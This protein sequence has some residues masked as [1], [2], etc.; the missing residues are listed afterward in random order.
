MRHAGG[1]SASLG[2][3]VATRVI[4]FAILGSLR[5][6][7]GDRTVAL[8]GGKQRALLAL[9]L[10]HRNQV[11]AADR[12]IEELWSGEPPAT[13]AKIVQLYVSQLRKALGDGVLV[14]R[15]PGYVLNV[16]GGGTRC[17]PLR[18]VAG[19]WAAHA[20]RGGRRDRPARLREALALWRGPPLSDFAYEAFAQGEI[21]RLAE[22]HLA[23]SRS[24]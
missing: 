9:L 7:E 6:F 24:G 21:A 23:S 12:L 5:V 14:T 8:G 3:S 11:V 19:G 4:E 1:V 2:D 20:R 13:A 18:A 17:G 16:E 10:L 15:S 22:L